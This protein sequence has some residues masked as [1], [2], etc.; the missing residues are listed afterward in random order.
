MTHNKTNKFDYYNNIIDNIDKRFLLV[1]KFFGVILNFS[2]TFLVNNV[3]FY[4]CN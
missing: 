2:D 1:T 4:K 3:H